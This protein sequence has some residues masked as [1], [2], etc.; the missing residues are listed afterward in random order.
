MQHDNR[1]QDPAYLLQHQYNRPDNLEARIALH[2]RFSTNPIGLHRWVLEQA[3]RLLPDR[4]R[5]LESGCGEGRLWAVA[6]DLVPVG[7]WITLTDFSPGM[8]AAAKERLSGTYGA[9]AC[10]R[11][12]DARNLPFPDGKFD[13]VFAHFVLHHVPD[14]AFAL[15]EIARVLRPGGQLFASTLGTGHLR[16]IYEYA[17]DFEETDSR[18]RWEI[19]FNLENGAVELARFFEDVRLLEFEDG[20]RVTEAEPLVAYVLSMTH[21]SRHTPERT[22]ALRDRITGQLA[23]FGVLEIAK[24]SGMFIGRKKEI[25][26]DG[27]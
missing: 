6:P 16:E 11:V 19:P 3:T 10:F 7:W 4:L 14:R 17:M 23:Q 21:P 2:E 18:Q 13:V 20:L 22:T 26:A 15:A 24:E 1:L 9:R 27:K 8:L 25:G 5:L 12:A